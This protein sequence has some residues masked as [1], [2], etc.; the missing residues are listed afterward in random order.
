LKSDFIDEIEY[1][2]TRMT[3]S[4]SNNYLNY[5]TSLKNLT[6]KKIFRDPYEILN[7]RQ[8]ML[9]DTEGRMVNLMKHRVSSEREKLLRLPDI[10]RLQKRLLVQK[11]HDMEL[12][13]QNLNNLSPLNIMSRGYSIV[14]DRNRSV[15]K[16]VEKINQ[17]DTVEI[18]FSDGS[19]VAAVNSVK[20][21][22]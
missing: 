3:N 7:S 13:I 15:I 18:R 8:M 16:S 4:L 22:N 5:K 19:A 6:S 14:L 11:K 12:L 2:K 1:L 10:Y 9:T 17:G 21:E 20:K